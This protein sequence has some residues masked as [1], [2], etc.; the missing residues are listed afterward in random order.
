MN[1]ATSSSLG[2][3]PLCFPGAV[4]LLHIS[5]GNLMLFVCLLPEIVSFCRPGWFGT[6]DALGFS[7]EI[8]GMSHCAKSKGNFIE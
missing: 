2:D 8:T 1:F 4:F 5:Q 6:R 7:A 3:P